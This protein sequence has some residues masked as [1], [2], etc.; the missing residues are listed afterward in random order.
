MGSNYTDIAQKIINAHP[1]RV[2]LLLAAKGIKKPATP[3]VLKNA[4]VLFGKPFLAE[5]VNIIHLPKTSQ[6]DGETTLTTAVES[7]TE[8][9]NIFDKL[10]DIFENGA[11]IVKTIGDFGKPAPIIDPATGKTITAE[12]K[13]AL[14]KAADDKQ[15]KTMLWIGGLVILFLVIVFAIFKKKQS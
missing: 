11:I 6:A 8:K 5:L 4:Y 12:E 2:R 14:D 7:G 3:E 15:A 9:K 1:D 13:A 10:Q